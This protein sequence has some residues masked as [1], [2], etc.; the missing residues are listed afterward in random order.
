MAYWGLVVPL[1]IGMLRLAG[2]AVERH[3]RHDGDPPTGTDEERLVGMAE[4]RQS[5]RRLTGKDFG[6]DLRGWHE[7]LVA[8]DPAGYQHPFAWDAVGPA[9]EAALGD[10][11]RLRLARVLDGAAG[12][13]GWRT[14]TVLALARGI[15]SDRDF[16]SLPILADAMED[17]GCDS[18]DVLGHCR[19]GQPHGD[20]CWVVALLLDAAE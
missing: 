4:G 18:A 2:Y 11:D 5:L 19:A 17:A 14:A 7:F 6:Y 13:R 8:H 16:H 20:A 12:V 15:A 3:G 9:I 10:P 1:Q